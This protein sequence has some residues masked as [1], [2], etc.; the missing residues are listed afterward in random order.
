MRIYGYDNI[1]PELPKTHMT[2]APLHPSR[3]HHRMRR[4]LSEGHGWIET[5]T[6][7]WVADDWLATLGFDPG[8]TL[9]V[10]NPIAANRRRLRTTLVPNLLAVANQNRK[11]HDRFRIYELG[12]IFLMEGDQKREEDQLAGVS[13]DGG[14]AE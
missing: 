2:P 10:R 7:G 12:R 11:S 9:N 5:Q 8:A 4:V 13:V 14:P 3:S 6:Y 1:T